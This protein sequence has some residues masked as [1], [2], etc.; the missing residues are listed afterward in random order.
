MIEEIENWWNAL[1]YVDKMQ[2]ILIFFLAVVLAI[3]TRNSK[4]IKK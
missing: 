2:F 1:A 3:N 4:E